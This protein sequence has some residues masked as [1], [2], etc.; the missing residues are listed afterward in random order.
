[1]TFLASSL[2]GIGI[3]DRSII[4]RGERAEVKAVDHGA[5]YVAARLI[6][7]TA[8]DRRYLKIDRR[9]PGRQHAGNFFFV[10][11]GNTSLQK[12]ISRLQKESLFCNWLT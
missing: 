7:V 10:H 2:D 3:G 9:Y 1:M 8:A 4:R 5:C 12:K 6:R 11:S